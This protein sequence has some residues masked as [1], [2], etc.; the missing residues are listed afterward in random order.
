MPDTGRFPP[1]RPLH[2]VRRGFVVNPAPSNI[3]VIYPYWPALAFLA[4]SLEGGGEKEEECVDGIER[5][6]NENER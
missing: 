6:G 4:L 1:G 5:S 2:G 3:F